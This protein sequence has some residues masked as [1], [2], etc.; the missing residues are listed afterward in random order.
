M[1]AEIYDDLV[2]PPGHNPFHV[3]G[4]LGDTRVTPLDSEPET[5][6]ASE[7]EPVLVPVPAS[8]PESV[9]GPNMSILCRGCGNPKSAPRSLCKNQSCKLFKE[10][11]N[12]LVTERV[13]NQLR[14]KGIECK[15][16]LDDDDG[17]LKFCGKPKNKAR[18]T[19][20]CGG[21]NWKTH[22]ET[23]GFPNLRAVEKYLNK[24]SS[25]SDENP[26]SK[27][28]KGDG[29]G[30]QFSPSEGQGTQ[31]SPSEGQEEQPPPPLIFNEGMQQHNPYSF[32]EVWGK[33]PEKAESKPKKI[34]RK[35]TK[36]RK[37]KKREPTKKKKL[38]KRR[39]N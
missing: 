17:K 14:K 26:T 3:S 16:I 21:T 23:Q 27:K 8:E 37:Q 18:S 25:Q 11:S 28:F 30:T 32:E 12:A 13:R 9:S 6:P 31:F 5:V 36:K 38:T 2:L 20:D 7:P 4:I 33:P 39:K 10:P 24:Q 15:L 35:M 34:K 19:C 29:Q 22:T 1:E